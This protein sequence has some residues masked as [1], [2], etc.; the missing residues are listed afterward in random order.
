MKQKSS[1][2]PGERGSAEPLPL[3]V[4]LRRVH[5]SEESSEP[6]LFVLALILACLDHALVTAPEN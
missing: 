5:L 6:D 2:G 4:R 3:E 1:F